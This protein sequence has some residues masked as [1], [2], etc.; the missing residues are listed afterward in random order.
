[1][2]R[3]CVVR[4]SLHSCMRRACVAHLS[5]P[6]EAPASRSWRARAVGYRSRSVPGRVK[7]GRPS[8]ERMGGALAP[9]RTP[10]HPLTP[11]TPSPTPPH[12]H[13]H[14]HICTTPLV[15]TA[16]SP[17][18]SKAEPRTGDNQGRTYMHMHMQTPRARGPICQVDAIGLS[19]VREY[20]C[21][22]TRV[23]THDSKVSLGGASAPPIRVSGPASERQ[24]LCQLKRLGSVL[25]QH[26]AHPGRTL[27]A[28][29]SP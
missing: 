10:I 26:T 11:H 5:R 6:W 19:Q 21:T 28:A 25:L 1:M 13:A 29:V 24:A 4:P 9:P 23:Q 20:V 16:L 14:V 18:L 15:I 17:W 3:I 7:A 22:Q 8:E 2:K 27:L 12:T